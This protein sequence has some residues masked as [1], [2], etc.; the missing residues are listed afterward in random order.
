M[1]KKIGFERLDEGQRVRV[2]NGNKLLQEGK[3]NSK[4]K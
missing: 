3:Q 2:P 1:G 4:Q